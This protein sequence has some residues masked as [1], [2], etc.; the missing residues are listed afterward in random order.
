[1]ANP[2]DVQ[3]APDLRR[4]AWRTGILAA[5]TAGMLA[6]AK[7]IA[8][9]LGH[10]TAVTAS[11]IDS[12]VDVVASTINALAIQLAGAKADREHP[13]GHG[14]IEALAT[15]FQGILVAG[16]ALYLLVQG[17]MRL[18]TPEPFQRMSFTL[19]VMGAVT[20]VNVGLV[21]H[22]R[23][24]ARRTASTALFADSV[25]YASDIAQNVG[26]LA[27]VAVASATGWLR[28]DGALTI[29]VAAYVARAGWGLLRPAVDELIDAQGDPERVAAL[30]RE[31]SGMRARGLFDDFHGLRTRVSGPTLFVEVHVELP[32]VM[33]LARAHRIGDEVRDAL[34]A[35]VPEADVLVHIDVERDE[36]KP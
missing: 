13:F 30:E 18:I 22:M 5:T 24:V 36:A 33:I 31:L 34:K 14:K 17:T 27:G 1:M 28:I 7:L 20:V 15:T 19:G 6:V 11:A 4:I 25:H 3:L 9:M 23:R 29:L 12:G 32:G 2:A 8:G 35:V 26:V 16:T 21:L 10:S